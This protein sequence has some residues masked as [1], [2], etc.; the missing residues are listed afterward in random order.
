MAGPG[1][2]QIG[3]SVGVCAVLSLLA[4]GGCERGCARREGRQELP[5][6][7]CA[8]FQLCHLPSKQ[9]EVGWR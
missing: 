9:G 6:R 5:E 8:V 3:P 2:P 7:E 4:A 1:P